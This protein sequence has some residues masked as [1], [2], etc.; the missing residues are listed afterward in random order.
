[1]L[2]CKRNEGIRTT[3]VINQDTP[4]SLRNTKANAL[5]CVQF[6]LVTGSLS[7][8]MEKTVRYSVLHLSTEIILAKVIERSE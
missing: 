6:S 4:L 3:V 1:M 2:V 5:K 7:Y 8:T